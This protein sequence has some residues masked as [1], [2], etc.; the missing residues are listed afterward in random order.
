VDDLITA[1]VISLHSKFVV[2]HTDNLPVAAG[3]A[4]EILAWGN[5]IWSGRWLRL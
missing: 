3:T 1:V 2:S 5:F 4:A